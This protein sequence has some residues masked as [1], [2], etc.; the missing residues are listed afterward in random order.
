[1]S[2]LI[3]IGYPDRETAQKAA[4]KV[5]E[6][7]KEYLI[8]LEQVAVVYR[9]ADGKLKSEAAQ[10]IV[11]VGAFGGMFWGALFGILFL[12]PLAGMAIGAGV[13]ALTGKFAQMGIRK[14]FQDKVGE[15]LTPGKAALFM[16][17]KKVTEDRVLPEMAAFGGEILRTSLSVEDEE[18]LAH[19]LQKD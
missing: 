2:E 17:V 4:A 10:G 6:L 14:D 16:V 11:G 8:E 15:L 9:E 5:G 3:V 7:Q 12:M 19:E 13:G 18:E 1:M